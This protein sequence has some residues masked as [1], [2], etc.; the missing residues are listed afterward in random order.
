MEKRTRIFSAA[1]YILVPLLAF[2]LI[3]NYRDQALLIGLIY[4][5]FTAAVT[6]VG[7]ILLHSASKNKPPIQDDKITHILNNVNTA[8]V[9]WNTDFSDVRVNTCLMQLTGFSLKECQSTDVLKKILPSHAFSENGYL[10][11]VAA[12]DVQ[13]VVT[14]KNGDKADIIWNTSLI[15][16]TGDDP[17]L[18]S[19][20]L[21]FSQ[22]AKMQQELT[23]FSKDLAASENRYS[24]SVELSEIGLILR[25]INSDVFFISEQVQS[26]LG[27]SKDHITAA[28]L[29]EKIH[30]NDR[31]LFD[32]YCET[33]RSSYDNRQIHN[34]EMRIIS[35]DKTYHWYN[36]RYKIS[37][38]EDGEVA[39]I[40]GAI[41]DI[42]RE[43]DKDSLIEKMA[44]IDEITQIFNRNKF[45]MIGQ[46]TLDC[47]I[48]LGISYWVIVLDIDKFHIINDTCGYQ[49]GNQLL[50]DVALTILK[51]LTTG[52]FPARIGGDN[53]ALIIKDDGNATLPLLT[54]RNIQEQL[55]ELTHGIFSNQTLTCSAG[56]C[57][58]P[59][60][61][62]DFAK[63][64]DHAE[65]ALSVGDGTRG[66][67]SRYDLTMHDSV[68]AGSALETELAAALENNEFVLYYQPKINLTNGEII[69]MEALIRWI[70]P[71][72]TLV[73]PDAFIPVAEN[74]LLITKISN[75]VL[76]EA[77][78]QNKAWQDAGLQKIT[79]SINLTS[80][81]FYQTDV[82]QSIL[83]V[84]QR[85]GLAP[86]YLEVELTESLALKDIDQAIHQMKEIKDLGV[87]L[88][89]DD[90]G[91][92]Y[93]SLSYIQV[94][95]I[96][97][98]KLDR[99]FIMYLE[100]DEVSRE[101]VSAVIRIAKSKKIETIAEGIE[102]IGQAEILRKSGCDLAQGYFFGRPM[103]AE[104]FKDF[105]LS[106]ATASV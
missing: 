40:G 78:R 58:M 105:L 62:M 73:P 6:C 93:S 37:E 67:V 100:N 16:R 44:Y 46:E 34:L 82:R 36:L 79:V 94:L 75:F 24:L 97:L 11:L 74:S 103:P 80:V 22:T 13:N 32:S 33:T 8:A 38:N 96:T 83:N 48:D 50:K 26:M 101:I 90:F 5:I 25:K 42:T 45:M 2:Y 7:I 43:K 68:I 89:M 95:P 64:L 69:G 61:G 60:D 18:L 15:G 21:D 91:T 81:D 19:I 65:F 77:C 3:Y 10:E 14:T 92:G 12:R 31:V 23:M 85:T 35:A 51:N 20:G 9:V 53:F 84:L 41:I 72:G 88:S 4:F 63:I 66:N 76:Y 57:R 70:K 54:I 49:N 59:E 99:S 86:Q 98:L 27:L 47:A 87:K 28:S 102:T 104:Q 56:Y 30:A 52:G 29:R 17:L 1:F 39:D 106:K 71:D 55:A